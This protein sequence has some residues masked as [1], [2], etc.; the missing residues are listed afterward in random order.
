[1][2]ERQLWHPVALA[3]ERGGRAARR[4][5]ARRR[6]RALARRARR[7]A[8]LAP[9]AARTAARSCRWAACD[10]R[11]AS[12]ARTTA[13]VRRPAAGACTCRRCP[14]SRRR[15]RTAPALR[16][17]AKRT[18]WCGCGWRPRRRRAAGLRRRGRRPP[19]QAQLR[20]L[21]G[22][23]QRA[24]PRRELPRHVAL[25]LRARRLAGRARAR[26]AIDDYR[27]EATPTGL[28]ATGCK[29]WQPQSNLHSTA[30]AQVEYSYEVTAPY[31]AVLTKMPEAG[32]VR[33]RGLARVDRAVH[34]PGRAGAQP[35]VVPPRRR[36]LRFARRRSCA[37]SRTPSSCRTSRCWNRS[38]PGACRWTCAPNCTPPPTG[39]RPPTAAT[40]TP[41]A[42]PSE[43]ADDTTVARRI[44]AERLPALLRAMPKAELHIHIEGS[45]EPEL[46][47]ALAQ[48]NG[49][50]LP[51]AERRGAA[52]APT[53]SPTCRAS[54]TSTTP[55]PACC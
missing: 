29:A 2:I 6:P 27:V 48:R 54:S 52:R 18:A 35:R 3:D 30:P 4:A 24:A 13:G 20:P 17:A 12:S 22:G 7:G 46:I 32:S 50:A 15:P 36:R 14:T 49:V 9:T 21:R 28:L 31:T 53:P 23:D 39:H 38:A 45:L 43:S 11:R 42:S 16:S 37:P 26:R 34:L 5:P 40:C 1:M 51:Y 33:R 10:E 8:R 41:A 47:F 19:A 55:A 25:R 44:P